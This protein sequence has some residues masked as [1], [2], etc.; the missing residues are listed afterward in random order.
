V[1]IRQVIPSFITSLNLVSGSLAVIFAFSGEIKTAVLLVVIAS[2]F[3]FFDGFAAR[4]LKSVSEFGKQLDSLSDLISFGFAPASIF[5][6]LYLIKNADDQIFAYFAILLVVFAALRLAKFN[7]DPEQTSEFKGLPTPAMALF[8]I[9]ISY[10]CFIEK[11]IISEFLCSPL[12]FV[13]INIIFSL[14]MISNI[15]LMSL[16]VKSLR[17]NEIY[18]QLILILG[19]IILLIIFR[20]LGIGL[21]IFLYLAISFLKQILTTKKK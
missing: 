14:L 8:I 16:K 20:F 18:W 2:V 11:T 1:K 6:N 17:I 10:Y 3:D 21:T 5:Y 12:I 13:S 4:L 19:A 15:R 9:S 7:I